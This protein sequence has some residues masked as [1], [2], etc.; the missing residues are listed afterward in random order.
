MLPQVGAGRAR[1]RVPRRRRRDARA[2]SPRST[3]PPRTARSTP[4]GRSSPS[5]AAAATC[6]AARSRRVDG[7]EV[8]RARGAARV[9]RRP[10]RAAGT[11]ATG[12]DPD[13]VGV[14]AAHRPARRQGGRV[15]ARRGRVAVTVYLVGAGPGDPG[16]LT[17]RGA[18]LLARA[19]VVVYDRLASP[20]LLDLAPAARRADRRRA[21]RPGRV[22]M[23]Q[24][25]INAVLVDRG[26]RGLDGRAP[27]GR[28]PVRVRAGRRGG[29]GAAPPRAS[30]FEVVPGITSAIGARRVRGHPGDAPRRCRRTSPSS[31]ATR[32]RP[33]ARTDADWDA[34]ARAGGTLVILMGAGRIGE[35]A[36]RADRRRPRRPTRRSPRSAAARGPT[37][38]RS[39]RRSA[40]IADAG[41]QAPSAIV[42]GAVAALDLAWFEP[43]PLFGRTVVVTRARE[44]ASELRPGS[45]RSAPRWSS[46]PPIAIEPRRRS[47]LPDLAAYAWLVFTS[48]NGVDAFFDRGLAPAGLDAACAGRSGS[49]DRPGTAAALVLA[50]A[51]P[52]DQLVGD[53]ELARVDVVAQGADGAG[54]DDP[55]DAELLHG[56]QVRP[57]VDHVRRE[58]VLLAMAGQ[59]CH[60]AAFDAAQG[61]RC[62][63]RA[64]WCLDR[65]LAGVVEEGVEARPPKMPISAR[66]LLI[67]GLRAVPC[68][69]LRGDGSLDRHRVDEAVRERAAAAAHRH[70]SDHHR[71][72]PALV[73][74]DR[75]LARAGRL[76]RHLRLGPFPQPRR[77][78]P[79][80][81]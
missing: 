77:P 79:S 7:D 9:A 69:G 71:R 54:A 66:S 8:R 63:R 70:Q 20:A 72:L 51:S 18:E 32:T 5:S 16:L 29:R 26:R 15:A 11:R 10:R 75:G 2:R 25:E 74:A 73:A 42:V 12:A 52:V 13:D 55:A 43:R 44:Q 36:Q 37:S 76:R 49:R 23:T 31:P 46:C 64:V 60:R 34:L 58:L 1:G 50:C 45:R 62:R 33:R 14:A 24:D 47:T 53:E 78:A 30:P 21:R 6:R 40:T 28:R 39:A 22:E 17:R 68:A 3:T 65:D 57:V 56:P 67:G 61:E 4:S 35:I 27:E 81:P 19:D 48:A 38:A 41:V 80:G 59:E